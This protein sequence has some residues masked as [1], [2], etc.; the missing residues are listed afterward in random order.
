[1]RAMFSRLRLSLPGRRQSGFSLIEVL[2]AL[3]IVGGLLGT[4]L[5]T[6]HLHMDVASDSGDIAEATSLAHEFLEEKFLKGIKRAVTEDKELDNGFTVHYEVIN[7]PL[8]ASLFEIRLVLKG[9]GQEV[10][11]NA[12]HAK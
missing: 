1:M 10:R 7:S 5:Y 6:L 12:L 8:E 9:R 4:L 2:V 3:A 11:L